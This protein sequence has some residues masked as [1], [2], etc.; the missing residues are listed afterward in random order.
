MEEFV[1]VE[2]KVGE[3]KINDTTTIVVSVSEWK[4]KTRLDIRKYVSTDAYKGP[5]KGGVSIP[6]EKVGE[7]DDI[8]NTVVQNIAG[9]TTSE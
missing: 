8:I 6:I 5:T 2:G 9:L 7:L 4:N 3:I 1:E